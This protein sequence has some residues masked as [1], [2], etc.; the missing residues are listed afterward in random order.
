MDE[1]E[2]IRAGGK[3]SPTSKHTDLWARYR[4]ALKAHGIRQVLVR[5]VPSH[6]EEGSDRI[7]PDDKAG[8]DH[9]DR[10]ANAHAK[11]IGPTARQGKQYHRRTSGQTPACHRKCHLPTLQSGEVRMWGRHLIAPH[12]TEGFRRIS[13]ARVANHK[14]A[15]YALRTLPCSGLAGLA[16][17][18]QPAR[19]RHK[20]NKANEARWKRQGEGGHQMVRYST[21]QHDGK[22]LGMR[23][24]LHYV[25]FCDLRT[26][27]CT[28]APA[29]QAATKA[30]RSGCPGRGTPNAKE[31]ACLREAPVRVQ[32]WSPRGTPPQAQEVIPVGQVG[33]PQGD[34]PQ[35]GQVAGDL[36]RVD[37]LEPP[38]PPATAGLGES[39]PTNRAQNGDPFQH[40]P[41]AAR[42][43]PSGVP[44]GGGPGGRGPTSARPQDVRAP[45]GLEPDHATPGGSHH[46]GRRGGRPQDIRAW[47]G[48][49]P[50]R[51][52]PDSP[53]GAACKVGKTGK[54]AQ[55]KA[56]ST[57]SGSAGQRARR[58]RTLP[59][60]SGDPKGH[61]QRRL[62]PSVVTEPTKR[63]GAP[64]PS[65]GPQKQAPHYSR[66]LTGRGVEPQPSSR[67][68]LG[69]PG[70]STDPPPG[71]LR[72]G[73][74]DPIPV[75][76]SVG[77]D[78]QQAARRAWLNRNQG[79][80]RPQANK[81]P[82]PS[83]GTGISPDTSAFSEDDD[84]PTRVSA[85]PD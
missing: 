20:W 79:S 35:Q 80:Q 84:P 82:L 75:G 23:C 26:K 74:P 32:T 3:V 29:S 58:P 17:P 72:R 64:G 14:R 60:P 83:W 56:K 85:I 41:G 31:G 10:L 50:G 19:P 49:G 15:R 5:W 69:A 18:L 65:S 76:R 9:A 24:G 55:P 4:D 12:G 25:R 59:E 6:E 62:V 37:V 67:H 34:G 7:S 33:S 1:A 16:G 63:G 61:M 48:L 81:A 66:S 54:P 73:A 70:S 53:K 44:T 8:N 52:V 39:A 51:G 57:P 43:T 47:L 30:I 45:L 68:L 78:G 46:E 40:D 11:L 36:G 13:C 27:R 22:W 38:E 71:S 28:A 42:P 2:R 77:H 21:T